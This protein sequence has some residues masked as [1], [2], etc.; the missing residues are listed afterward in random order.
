MEL[1][2][3]VK[4]FVDRDGMQEVCASSQ[5]PGHLDKTSRQAQGNRHSS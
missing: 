1:S 4:V 3:V 5:S 2:C